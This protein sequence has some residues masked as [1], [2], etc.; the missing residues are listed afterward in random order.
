MAKQSRRRRS[1]QPKHTEQLEHLPVEKNGDAQSSSSAF[2]PME[3]FMQAAFMPFAWFRP[4]L[5]VP[6][7]PKLDVIDRDSSV[8][9]R[10]EVPGVRKN[11][12]EVEA[13]DVSLTIK[14]EVEHEE[15]REDQR[16]RIAETS[17]GAFVRTVHL[18]SEVDSAKARATFKDGVVEVTL[19]KLD[20]SRPHQLKL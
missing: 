14:G 2:E 12:L 18:P 6:S 9:V 17:R 20:R 13:S 5:A 19:P 3:R 8:L 15:T 16:Y 4:W 11:R 7:A 10:A 1:S